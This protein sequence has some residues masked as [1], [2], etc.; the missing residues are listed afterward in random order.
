VLAAV[1]AE[2]LT[3]VEV[4]A[5]VLFMLIMLPLFQEIVIL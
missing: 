3:V 4:E 1:A 5:E 2:L